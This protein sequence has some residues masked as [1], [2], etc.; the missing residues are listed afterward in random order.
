MHDTLTPR[1][2]TAAP[3]FAGK[4]IV[5]HDPRRT[6]YVEAMGLTFVDVEIRRTVDDVEAITERMM[7]DSGAT[8]SVIPADVLSDLGVKPVDE[9]QYELA[10]GSLVTL[11]RAPV[12]MRLLGTTVGTTVIFGPTGEKALL[13]VTVLES[14]GATLDAKTRTLTR[15]PTRL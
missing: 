13:G 15:R 10:D 1:P 9:L 2:A 12:V 5:K 3:H 8:D 6:E 7:V 4:L 11:A 14:L